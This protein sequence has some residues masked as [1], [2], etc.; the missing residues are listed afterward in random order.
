MSMLIFYAILEILVHHGMASALSSTSPMASSLQILEGTQEVKNPRNQSDLL[1]LGRWAAADRAIL[2][3]PYTLYAN[4][5]QLTP[6]PTTVVSRRQWAWN[7]LND[8]VRTK[9]SP[10]HEF[11][12]GQTRLALPLWA[13]WYNQDE[14]SL[15]FGRYLDSAQAFAQSL[16]TDVNLKQKKFES[17]FGWL[18]SRWLNLPSLTQ[19][20]FFNRL[21]KLKSE[22]DVLGLA[23]PARILFSP[24][25]FTHVSEQ[26]DDLMAC[27]DRDSEIFAPCLPPE[28]PSGAA[29]MKFFWRRATVQTSV[30][31]YDTSAS[32]LELLLKS[33]AVSQWQPTGFTGHAGQLPILKIRLPGGEEFQLLAFHIMV[34]AS[35][36]WVWASFWW[37][38][39]PDEDFGEDRPS[40]VSYPYNQYKMCAAFDFSQDTD[41]AGATNPTSGDRADLPV[42]GW[43]SLSA[44]QRV[45]QQHLPGS[46]WC[47]N[48]YLEEGPGNVATNCVGCH[49][50]AG[51]NLTSEDVLKFDFQGRPQ[52]LKN[53]LT[54]YVW[55]ARSGSV[56]FQNRIR[57]ALDA[58]F[59]TGGDRAFK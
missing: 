38:P 40:S 9:L 31:Y 51:K 12:S 48:P 59:G 55:S 7:L 35:R 6:L 2:G 33:P 10:V 56:H 29:V 5:S 3:G 8:V 19:E 53:S 4:L 34:K 21:A 36:H 41:P 24:E 20:I 39:K 37:S 28:F 16:A 57:S 23:G 58:R 44:A 27:L 50:Y 22:V 13:T 15:F 11:G 30:P 17:L 49:Q 25:V 47:S 52:A 42:G 14:F 26:A 46:S 43:P 18:N 54:D 45:I 32:A 1:S